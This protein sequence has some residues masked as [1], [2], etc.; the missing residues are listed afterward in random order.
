MASCSAADRGAAGNEAAIR[1]DLRCR[2]ITESQVGS[3][4]RL[5]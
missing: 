1:L 3:V 5:N 4:T 2:R